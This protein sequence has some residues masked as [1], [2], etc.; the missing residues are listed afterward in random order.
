MGAEREGTPELPR[1]H[2]PS[3]LASTLPLGGAAKG[4]VHKFAANFLVPMF[5]VESLI[6][7]FRS[8][9]FRHRYGHTD[10]TA[11][12]PVSLSIKL[13]VSPVVL[14]ELQ[15]SSAQQ[16]VV[17]EGGLELLVTSQP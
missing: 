9:E 2:G 10:F 6:P 3:L 15:V 8:R 12:T 14:Y 1:P 13:G 16:G 17:T 11:Q 4:I 7:I 5:V